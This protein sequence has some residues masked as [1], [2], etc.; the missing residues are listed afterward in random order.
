M[1]AMLSDKAWSKLGGRMEQLKSMLEMGG[2]KAHLPETPQQASQLVLRHL[3]EVL[4]RTLLAVVEG[5]E[6][7]QDVES[8]ISEGKQGIR[9]MIEEVMP[10]QAENLWDFFLE[11][12]YPKLEP[13]VR[14]ILDGRNAAGTANDSHTDD[15]HLTVRL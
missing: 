13:L 7:D 4:S 1:A 9:A 14:S 15:L 6:Q 12:V 10:D 8:I 2:G 3:R 5:N 11:A